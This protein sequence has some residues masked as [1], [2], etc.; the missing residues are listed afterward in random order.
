M[1]VVFV[2]NYFNHH[3][4][5]F[6]D[7]MYGLLGKDYAFVETA[8][9]S[10]DRKNLG[11]RSEQAPYTIHYDNNSVLCEE[12]I[13]EADVVVIG[14][15]PKKLVKKRMRHR[16]LVFFYSERIYKNKKRCKTYYYPFHY[17]YL[18]LQ[19]KKAKTAY[20]LSASAY[21]AADYAKTNTFSNKCYKWGYFPEMKKYE[22]VDRIIEEKYPSSIIWVARMIDWKHPEIPISIAKRLKSEG[23]TFHVN[24]VGC[25]EMEDEIKSLICEYDVADCVNMLGSMKPE[26]VREYMEKSQIFMFTS[27]RNEG[28]GAV[29][30][31]AMNSACAVVASHAIGSVPFLLNDRVNGLIYQDGNEDDLYIKIKKLLDD[32]QLCRTYGKNAYNTIAEEWNAEFVTKRF[33]ELAEVI[34]RGDKVSAIFKT[35]P[36][37]KAEVLE[38]GWYTT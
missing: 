2:S 20:A 35:G 14:S 16:R 17:L 30:N 36:C 32:K 1:K 29:L 18:L 11:W 37:S 31:E 26:Q 38:D 33:I 22:D 19:G 12:L 9:I 34:L 27:D 24:M 7:A 25:G 10:E 28:W 15:A 5:P 6:S 3:Q 8:R 4:K 13:N 23:Y 21:A